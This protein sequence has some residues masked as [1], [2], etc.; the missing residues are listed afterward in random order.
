M[1]Q[2]ED[3]RA[4]THPQAVAPPRT[5]EHQLEI[6][7]PAPL[8][9]EINADVERWPELTPT[10][11]SVTLLDGPLALG[12]RARIEQPGQ[13]PT[14]WT[15]TAFEPGRTF[16]WE[17]R[18]LGARMVATHLVEP[19]ATGA[20]NTLRLDLHGLGGRVLALVLGRTLR[21]VLATEN[22]GFRAEAARR[23]GG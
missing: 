1:H 7:A 14:I 20:R 9:F 6:E 17:A 2:I 11:R 4:R 23:L 15:V 16:S 19:T 3:H 13:R 5:I 22:A 10:V 8:V 21:R 18:T 12:A